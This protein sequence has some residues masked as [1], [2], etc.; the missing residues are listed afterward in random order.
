MYHYWL[1]KWNKCTPLMQDVNNRVNWGEEERDWILEGNFFFL[2][3]F[4]VAKTTPPPQKI[5][6]KYK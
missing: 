3:E 4:S 6:F 1:T 2:L 5:I